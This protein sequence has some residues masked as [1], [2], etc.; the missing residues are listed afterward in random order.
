MSNLRG[1][2]VTVAGAGVMGL[3]AALR[4]VDAGA[5][6]TLCDPAAAGD[7]ASGVAAGMLAPGFESILDASSDG[8]FAL[9]SRAR[10]LWPALARRVGLESGLDRSGAAL[11][12]FAGEEDA[13]AAVEAKMQ[14]LGLAP[15]R[16]DA[17]ALRRSA[18]GLSGGVIAGLF[19]REDWRLDPATA[20]AALTRAFLDA[21]GQIS[22]GRLEA[23]DG[24]LRLGGETVKGA[25]VLAI[26]AEVSGLSALVP[27]LAAL[28][29]VKGQIL[30][31]EAG[32]LAGPVIRSL[33]GYVA[34]QSGGALAGATME[35][36]RSD[37]TLDP[38]VLAG[39]RHDAARLFPHLATAAAEG[40]AGV[41]AA[42]PDSLP[43]V[44]RSAAAS[45]VEIVLCTGARRN[46]WL[47]APL[48]AEAVAAALSGA[49]AG[50][51]SAFDPARFDRPATV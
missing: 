36:G 26:G 3:A 43:L 5:A 16:L 10:D 21:G 44:G 48:A 46:G 49:E 27:E 24:R 50:I 14:A 19:T 25:V 23:V 29:P 42:T 12:S 11:C 33:R 37:R 32:P 38:A 45:D 1:L 47:L 51:G 40:R 41:R 8:H 20:L 30:R 39:L 9:L 31:F 18:P 2:S 7:N 28:S 15:E 6:V 22:T 34:P 35:A 17:A 4:L 13:L